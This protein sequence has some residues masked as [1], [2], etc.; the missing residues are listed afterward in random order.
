MKTLLGNYP[1]SPRKTRL[2]ADLV[3]GKRL[4]E[5]LTTLSFTAKRGAASL[6]KAIASA[7]ASAKNNK[8]A[9]V[10]DLVIKSIRVDKGATLKR[11][12]PISRGRVGPFRRRRSRV[13]VE[14]GLKQ[15]S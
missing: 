8:G 10:E 1:Q 3:K 9:K 11:F 7:A 13:I 12:R 6:A 15:E 2:L 4:S 14:L 5:A